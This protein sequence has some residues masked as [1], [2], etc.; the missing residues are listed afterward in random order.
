[1]A[2]LKGYY[3]VAE[4]KQGSS[5][6]YYAIYND[7]KTYKVGDH[8]IVSGRCGDVLEITDI[9]APEEVMTNI[10]AEVI[11]KVDTTAYNK[12]IEKR[13]KAEELKKKMDKMIKA[14]DESKKYEMYAEENPD[15]AEMLNEYKSLV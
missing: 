11:C 8:V 15:L 4:T 12:R 7:G 1:M 13:K 10:C 6:Y 5:H 14:M 9:L 2:V 3:A